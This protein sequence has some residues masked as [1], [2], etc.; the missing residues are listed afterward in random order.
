MF[1]KS[2]KHSQLN[3]LSTPTSFLTGSS[4]KEYEDSKGWHNQFYTQVTQRID[5]EQFRPLFCSDNGAPNASICV[6]VGMMIL[7]EGQG[8]SDAKL[9]EECRF[10]LLTRRALGLFNMDD[11]LPAVSTYY[12]LRKRIVEREKAGNENL[13]EKVFAQLT[14][15]QAIEFHVNG[16]KLRMDSKLLGSNI[17]WYS[18]YELVH[19]TLGKAY[20]SIKSE[21]CHLSLSD[22]ER[23]LMESIL[24]ESGDKVVYRSNREEVESKMTTLGVLIYKII[25]QQSAP[26]SES[27]QTLC[28]VFHD[29]YQFIENESEENENGKERIV[30]PRPK[31]AIS[32]KSVQSPHDAEC[33]YRNKDGNQVKGYSINLTETCDAGSSLNLITNVMV[34]VVSTAD[35]D[36]LQPAI[37]ATME[38]ITQEI[39]TVNADGA[40]NSVSNQNYCQAEDIDLILSAIQGK[41]SQ[42]DLSCDEQGELVVT[43]LKTNEIVPSHKI[44]SRKN[45]EQPKWAIKNEKGKNRYFTQKEIDSCLLR[46]QAAARTQA[47]LNVR[48]NVEASIFQLGYHYSND[49]SRYRGLSKHKIWANARCLWINF[50]RIVNYIA[51]IGSNCVQQVKNRLNFR[52]YLLKYVETV[53]I[54][55]IVG[56]FYP[57]VQNNGRWTSANWF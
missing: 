40:Y 4:L 32:A 6:L 19:E 1:K 27:M 33:H 31:E 15:S 56:N 52:Q 36:F 8:L 12:L 54:L 51:R 16:K 30:L 5:E 45:C 55:C 47:E 28:R 43:D 38:V 7:K 37:E 2:S 35:C 3:L 9:F 34:D 48:N 53:F 57:A 18:R 44:V 26:F 22:S 17:A 14:K 25:R 46:K 11:S 23:E 24:S 10:N 21:I 41:P 13:I 42:Y 49:K 29:Q 50:V 20:P 39:E